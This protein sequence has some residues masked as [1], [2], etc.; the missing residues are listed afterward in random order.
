MRVVVLGA[1][2]KIARHLHGKLSARGHSVRGL[3]RNPDHVADLEAAGVEPVVCD[4]EAHDD[5]SEA[6]GQAEA[7]VFAAGAGP[8][9]GV[10]RKWTVD[11]DGAIKL[12]EAARKN[13]I[14]RYVMVSAMHLDQPRGDEVFRTY[15]RA[16]AEADEALRESGLDYTIV[17][18]GRLTD[19]PGTGRV[20]LGPDLPRGEIPRED[21]ASVL[22]EVL[23]TP[24]TA[25]HS[26]DLV[27]GETPIRDA[28][29]A[30]VRG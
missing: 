10:A 21:V 14:R 13:G 25:G 6:V 24:A 22:A 4:V 30:V 20:A 28:V 11:R 27:A 9:S 23:D 15:L 16:K 29:E 18:P 2:G 26:F 17:K 19:E 3:V 1:H 8:G 5:I 12:L 7:V